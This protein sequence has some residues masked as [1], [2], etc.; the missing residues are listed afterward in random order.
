VE[1]FHARANGDQ[2]G[3]DIECIRDDEDDEEYAKDRTTRPVETLDSQFAQT[4]AGREGCSIA[5]LLDRR[6]KRKGD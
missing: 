5:Y 3:R 2:V 4:R 6:H 1:K